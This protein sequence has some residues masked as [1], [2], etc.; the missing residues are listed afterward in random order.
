MRPGTN[1]DPEHPCVAEDALSQS[2]QPVTD[3]DTR[4]C[5]LNGERLPAQSEGREI[6]RGKRQNNGADPPIDVAAQLPGEPGLQEVHVALHAFI[7]LRIRQLNPH[8]AGPVC[9]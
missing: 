8:N 3:V 6:Y 1:R 7:P 9:G 2:S 4:I 5:V